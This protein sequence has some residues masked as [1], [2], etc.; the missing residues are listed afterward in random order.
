MKRKVTGEKELEN[1]L[2]CGPDWYKLDNAGK[3]YPAIINSKDSCVFRISVNLKEDVIPSVLQQAACDCKPRFPSL[4]VKLRNGFFWHYYESNEKDPVIKPDSPHINEH[5]DQY[6]NN[7]Y[8]FTLFY[9][10]NRISI[11]TFHGLCDG[12]GAMEFFKSLIYRYFELIG[13]ETEN[14]GEVLTIDQRPQLTEAEDSFLENYRP[15]GDKRIRV[16]DAYRLKGT[17]FGKGGTGVIKGKLKAEQLIGLAKKAGAT[18]TQYLTA[19]LIYCIAQWDSEARDSEKPVNICIPVNM[20]RFFNSRTLRNF[21]LY[22]YSSLK[23]KDM[24]IDFDKILCEVIKSFEQELT[25][26]KLQQTLNVNVSIEKNFIFRICPLIIKD[27]AIRIVCMVLADKSN[28]SAIANLG[29]VT[30]PAS[31]SRHIEDFDC[32]SGLGNQA[33][34]ALN[35]ITYNG[36]MVISFSRAVY[37]TELE[38]LFFTFLTDQGIDVEIESNLW[39]D[40]A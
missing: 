25:K 18:P 34:H 2:D 23:L 6:E 12:G 33:T 1:L 21:S 26:E 10:K 15:T 22:F 39:E 36:R 32:T 29:N 4:Y 3:I 37:E 5:I 24:D 16:E 14:K 38:R 20:R 17:R 7:G 28:T 19:L 11:E 35:F 27:A 9:H 8:L 31:L 40:Y 13:Y 30:M